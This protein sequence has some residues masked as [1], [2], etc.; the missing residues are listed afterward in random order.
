MTCIKHGAGA[1]PRPCPRKPGRAPARTACG[2]AR[3]AARSA[4]DNAYARPAGAGLICIRAGA[5]ATPE[6]ARIFEEM[7]A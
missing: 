1:H 6:H 2:D 7:R 4:C 3:T 5:P